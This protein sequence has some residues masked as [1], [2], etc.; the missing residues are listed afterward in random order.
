MQQSLREL[1]RAL[2]AKRKEF[3]AA[4]QKAL[5]AGALR[6][7][8]GKGRIPARL[9]K[10]LRVIRIMELECAS[11]CRYWWLGIAHKTTKKLKTSL[12]RLHASKGV[13]KTG[14]F[15]EQNEIRVELLG[16][17][18]CLKLG[19]GSDYYQS[20]Y[21]GVP[22]DLVGYSFGLRDL[23]IGAFTRKRDAERWIKKIERS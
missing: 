21:I 13:V 16:A 15:V 6:K 12:V 8:M 7:D 17:K 9:L 4:I 5:R 10:I 3:E 1:T 2:T 19:S 18:I 23:Y 14:F 20:V 11:R 22:Q